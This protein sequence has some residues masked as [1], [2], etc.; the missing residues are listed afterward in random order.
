MSNVIESLRKR[1]FNEPRRIVFPE[2]QDPRVVE[3]ATG[4]KR[5]GFGI[6]VL[7]SDHPVGDLEVANHHN[8]ALMESCSQ[9]LYENRKHKG[10][11][12]DDARQLIE[13]D[14]LLFGALLVRTGFAHGSVAGSVATTAAVIRAGLY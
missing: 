11:S 14:P 9:Q 6:P 3:A 7:I 10:L 4:F 12:L 8:L 5:N 13:V 1:A 2:T